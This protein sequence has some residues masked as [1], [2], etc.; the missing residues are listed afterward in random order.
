[1]APLLRL[2]N[3]GDRFQFSGTKNIQVQYLKNHL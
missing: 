1:M 3:I 2:L